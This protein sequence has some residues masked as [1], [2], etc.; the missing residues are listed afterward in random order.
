M[1]AKLGPNTYLPWNVHD[2]E[3]PVVHLTCGDDL[4]R[5]GYR[6]W[7]A[8]DLAD[9]LFYLIDGRPCD[10]LFRAFLFSP[11]RALSG[12][13]LNP[14]FTG[15]EPASNMADWA[16][17]LDELFRPGFH[18]HALKDVVQQSPLPCTPVDVWVTLPY[19][20]SRQSDFG[21]V[22]GATLDFQSKVDRLTAVNW[23][24]GQ[25]VLR[26]ETSG[27][28]GPLRLRGFRWPREV[29]GD[30]DADFIPM[31]STVVHAFG[32]QFMWLTNYGSGHVIEWSDL[33]FDVIALH[34]NY[35]GNTA[36]DWNWID[37]ASMFAQ[38]YRCGMQVVCGKGL[39][40][41]ENHIYDYLNRGLPAYNGYMRQAFTVMTF[42]QVSPRDLY[43]NRLP[44]YV[45]VYSFVKGIYQKW[46]YPT[47]RY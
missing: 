29:V 43:Q 11:N 40:Y 39:L 9:Y 6:R 25:F 45:A 10:T 20:D 24:I 13:F 15:F 8:S 41:D 19:P 4:L 2:N 3:S 42:D 16:E 28:E 47:M 27:L 38:A 12:R 7:S 22:S 31:V 18:L 26:W 5:S 32:R 1:E 21:T 46:T 17:W 37:H 44:V 30:V 36:L 14:V 34:P 35:Y 33:G 23:W